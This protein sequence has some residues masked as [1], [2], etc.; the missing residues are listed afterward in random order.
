MQVSTYCLK[1]AELPDV[2]KEQLNFIFGKNNYWYG[3]KY[4]AEYVNKKHVKEITA[5]LKLA[6]KILSLKMD[7]AKVSLCVDFTIYI[8]ILSFPL[9]STQFQTLE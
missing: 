8:H 5:K 7:N 9:F 3:E 4:M 2:A 1:F 6:T